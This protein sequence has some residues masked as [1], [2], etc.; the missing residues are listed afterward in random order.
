MGLHSEDAV[1]SLQLDSNSNEAIRYLKG[2]TLII[3]EQRIHRQLSESSSKGLCLVCIDGFSMGWA[4]WQ[5]GMLKNEYPS[6][7]RWTS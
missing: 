5:D 6:G 1:R 2:E 4:K 7:W 3:E